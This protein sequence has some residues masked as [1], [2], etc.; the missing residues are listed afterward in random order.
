MIPW[1]LACA[2]LCLGT[3]RP[4][5]AI[6]EDSFPI[7]VRPTSILRGPR[8]KPSAVLVVEWKRSLAAPFSIRILDESGETIGLKFR[9]P[10][11]VT[12]VGSPPA[13]GTVKTWSSLS[14]R[15]PRIT[16]CLPSGVQFP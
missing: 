9:T 12:G 3:N 1:F 14:P 13:T 7:E 10:S 16:T 2:I 15:L 5:V 4:V 8:E 6:E 11:G